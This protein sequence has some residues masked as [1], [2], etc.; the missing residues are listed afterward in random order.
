MHGELYGVMLYS[1]KS[2]NYFENMLLTP[3]TP[4]RARA[5]PPDDVH[6]NAFSL[7]VKIPALK[8]LLDFET[9]P[10]FPSAWWVDN[11]WK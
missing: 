11:E 2:P 7:A 9:S 3:S 5:P 8:F 6:A 10:N 1:R 4:G